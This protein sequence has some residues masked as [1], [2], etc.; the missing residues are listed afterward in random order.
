MRTI[1][2]F[3]LLLIVWSH[4]FSQVIKQQHSTIVELNEKYGLVEDGTGKVVLSNEYDTV[5]SFT[6]F[7][8]VYSFRKNNKFGYAYLL[9][10]WNK[11][12]YSWV[13]SECIYDTIYYHDLA[14]ADFLIYKEKNHLK[15]QNFE[16]RPIYQN[17]GFTYPDK[18]IIKSD[19]TSSNSYDTLYPSESNLILKYNDKYGIHI[20]FNHELE[21][22]WDSITQYNKHY[23]VWKG[24]NFAHLTAYWN[25]DSEEIAKA[26]NYILTTPYIF[27]KFNEIKY[28]DNFMF[29]VQ[30]DEPLRIFENFGTKEVVIHF[31]NGEVLKVDTAFN[32]NVSVNSK[33]QY[34]VISAKFKEESTVIEEIKTKFNKNTVKYEV[35]FDRFHPKVNQLFIVNKNGEIVRSM[36][37]SM[38]IYYYNN[39]N[40]ILEYDYSSLN[41]N[42]VPM[43]VIDIE[44]GKIIK[45]YSKKN[46]IYDI[47]YYSQYSTIFATKYKGNSMS[48]E[49]NPQRDVTSQIDGRLKKQTIGYLKYDYIKK[50]HK[51]V[52]FKWML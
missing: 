27:R 18:A 51:I 17:N 6:P 22:Q 15:Y 11:E 50:M 45:K 29:C 19:Y 33:N 42:F 10:N 36:D 5:I 52:R 12:T 24:E 49:T 40:F 25:Y 1:L 13:V 31:N 7:K 3:L 48:T 43:M 39:D 9:F 34:F 4:C 20:G 38:N 46:T 44:S 37:S 23:L 30:H 47:E 21:C 35:I 28:S 32:Y 26:H 8:G 2:C 16:V 41:P 14:V